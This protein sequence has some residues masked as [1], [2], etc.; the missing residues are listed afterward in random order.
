MGRGG[1]ATVYRARE[2]KHDRA[3]AVKVIHPELTLGE[4][5]QRFQRE[6]QITSHLQHA[7]V[8]PLLDSG[9]AG[10]LLYYVTPFIHGA[11][12]REHLERGETKSLSQATRIARDVAAGLDHAHRHGVIHRDVK[13]ANIMVSDGQA[14]VTDFGI[15]K[16]LELAPDSDLTVVGA[17]MGTVAYMSPEQLAGAEV[18]ARS[19][20]FSL[21]CIIYEMLAGKKPFGPSEEAFA[22][23][24]S[25]I[26]APSLAEVRPD[27]PPHV[28]YAV[29]VALDEDPE[30]RFATAG[31]FAAALDAAAGPRERR[32]SLGRWAAVAA[33]VLVLAAL[34]ALV[35]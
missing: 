25:R 1:M 33:A 26:R 18:D 34:L 8:L 23:P 21:A 7:H 28:A 19:D 32:T 35:L 9:V 27:L 31:E 24:L 22:P 17:V 13:P 30:K 15:A 10:G 29:G 20:V 5:V 12:L 16:A 14:I 3:V 6:I 11:S 2:H 4:G